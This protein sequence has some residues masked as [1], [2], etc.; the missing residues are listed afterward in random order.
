MAL[1]GVALRPHDRVNG[2]RDVERATLRLSERSLPLPKASTFAHS[3]R[4][5]QSQP[6][7]SDGPTGS[8][9]KTP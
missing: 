9:Y 4:A 6:G 2:F 1:P 8:S 7:R 3:P 5:P